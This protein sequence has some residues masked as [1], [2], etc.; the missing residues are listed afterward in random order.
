[1][2]P[3]SSTIPD[4]ICLSHLRWNFVFQRPQHLLTRCAR[5]R[6]VY[7]VEEPIYDDRAVPSMELER[8]GGVT[9]AVPHLPNGR[10][11]REV[12]ETQRQLLDEL[13]KVEAIARVCA[14]VLHTDGARLHRASDPT[15]DRLRLHGRTVGVRERAGR[16]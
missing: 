14:L 12:V 7:Y 4:L 9:V 15:G 5:E 11:D 8:S 13:M 16:S 3:R 1:M 2:P 6:R 10:S